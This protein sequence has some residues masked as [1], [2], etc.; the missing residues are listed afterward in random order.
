MMRDKKCFEW[1]ELSAVSIDRECL[2]GRRDLCDS[3]AA[4]DGFQSGFRLWSNPFSRCGHE[5]AFTYNYVKHCLEHAALHD[6]SASQSEAA[7]SECVV[8]VKAASEAN[9]QATN[10]PRHGSY[11]LQNGTQY[12]THNSSFITHNSGENIIGRFLSPDP[13]LQDP[14]NAQNYNKY[15]Y[16]LNNP[17]K[18]TDPSGYRGQRVYRLQAP[19]MLAENRK[20][21]MDRE[22]HWQAM[23]GGGDETYAFLSVMCGGGGGGGDMFGTNTTTSTPTCEDA[24]GDGNNPGE[25]YLVFNGSTLSC[26]YNGK[27]IASVPAVSGL[28][29]SNGEFEYSICSQATVNGPIPEGKYYIL[30]D[31]Y[32]ECTLWDDFLGS[33]L[34]GTFLGGAISWGDGKNK[35]YPN[36]LDVF[37]PCSGETVSRSGWY[38]HGGYAPGSHGCIDVMFNM[39]AISEALSGI[40]WQDKI[41]IYVHY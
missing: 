22:A 12:Q 41:T 15:S 28:P 23:H 36:S 39:G 24:G 33:F 13:V 19:D 35:I 18:F 3:G 8:H 27:C 29:N 21:N 2:V 31:G 6:L 37:N 7:R 34:R 40:Y 10:Y 38:L 26:Y 20:L 1:A 16:V 11:T 9:L 32:E 4:A 17:L 30:I 5:R 14:A 25:V